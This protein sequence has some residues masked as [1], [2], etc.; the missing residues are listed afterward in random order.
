MIT[1]VLDVS[2]PNQH[3]SVVKSLDTTFTSSPTF[4]YDILQGA[5][6][7]IALNFW[8][9]SPQDVGDGIICFTDFS[10]RVIDNSSGL[11]VT[12]VT[13]ESFT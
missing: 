11:E 7:P 3:I 12:Y 10:S 6:L 8:H 1:I 13:V 2:C 4:M 9:F 5:V